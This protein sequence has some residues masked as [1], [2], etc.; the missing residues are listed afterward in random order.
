[1]KP[2]L[3]ED[4]I[5]LSEFK[6]KTA[7]YLQEIRTKGRTVVLTQ[8]GHSAAVILS[9]ESYERL[10]YEKELFAAIAKGE[11]ELEEGKGIPHEKVFKQLFDRLSLK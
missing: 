2:H 7:S 5:P 11:R 10:Q 6:K 8:N 4:I 9:P 1:M 3:A